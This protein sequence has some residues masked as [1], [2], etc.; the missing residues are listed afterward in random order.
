MKTCLTLPTKVAPRL[1]GMRVLVGVAGVV[2]LAGQCNGSQISDSATC[3]VGKP[4][5]WLLFFEA[6]VIVIACYEFGYLSS[7][8][9]C[10]R[11]HGL[12]F[13]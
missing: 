6:I 7:H 2:W 5:R 10:R 13:P 3:L 9:H 8:H 1:T 12:P 4:I 11:R